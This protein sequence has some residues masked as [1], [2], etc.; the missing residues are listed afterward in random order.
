DD[1]VTAGSGRGNVAR[2]AAGKGERAAAYE[3]QAMDILHN[4]SPIFRSNDA[5]TP[6]SLVGRLGAGGDSLL[7]V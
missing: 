7:A 6:P 3:Q 4:G 2:S 5:A 1:Y